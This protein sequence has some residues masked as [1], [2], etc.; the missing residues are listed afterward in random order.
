[1]VA[2]SEKMLYGNKCYANIIGFRATLNIPTY[3][4]C[5]A[6]KL[7]FMNTT[8]YQIYTTRN[9]W[10][11]STTARQQICTALHSQTYVASPEETTV[12]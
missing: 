9:A 11:G 4:C 1:M 10:I 6:V 8:H 3:T 5:C 2:C 7:L 12:F